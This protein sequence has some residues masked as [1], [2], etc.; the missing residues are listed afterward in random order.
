M[1]SVHEAMKVRMRFC[2]QTKW[3][4]HW[5]CD[6]NQCSLQYPIQERRQ[7]NVFLSH[8]TDNKWA[9]MPYRQARFSVSLNP[10]KN[11]CVDRKLK[12]EKKKEKIKFVFSEYFQIYGLE[13]L[14][15]LFAL[16]WFLDSYHSAPLF[17]RY[18]KFSFNIFI[19][20][21]VHLFHS[22]G[23]TTVKTVQTNIMHSHF[24]KS[25]AN[26][27]LTPGNWIREIWLILF[28]FFFQGNSYTI[29]YNTIHICYQLNRA[30]CD[31][32]RILKRNSSV[33]SVSQ[34]LRYPS[35]L[36]V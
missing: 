18:R 32:L 8:V 4:I 27:I 26:D 15:R 2:S 25:V 35:G 9:Y 12:Q 29:T 22:N 10:C 5:K 13:W 21:S 1:C 17:T 11:S 31:M 28:F 7:I 19:S 6:R 14:L 24:P 20:M 33:N 34:M 30:I 36:Y 3:D 16:K 23:W